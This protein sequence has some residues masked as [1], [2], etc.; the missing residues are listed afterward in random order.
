MGHF[1]E[2]LNLAESS[3]YNIQQMYEIT[4][5]GVDNR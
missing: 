1:P 4:L 5:G 2:R 3:H